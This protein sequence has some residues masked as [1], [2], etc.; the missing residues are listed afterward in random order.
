VTK[1]Y[2][3]GTRISPLGLLFLAITSAGW[4]LS[5]PIMKNLLTEWPP[6]GRRADCAAL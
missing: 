1:P 3:H 6:R 5:F 2:Q 4:G